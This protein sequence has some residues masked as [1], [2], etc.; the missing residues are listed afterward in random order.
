MKVWFEGEVIDRAYPNDRYLRIVEREYSLHWVDEYSQEHSVVV[1]VNFITD[2]ASVPRPL[3]NIIPPWDNYIKDAAVCHDRMY[4]TNEVD[5]ATADSL[6]YY[7]M[8]VRGAS[9]VGA[10]AVWT[11]VRLFGQSSYE[12]GEKRQQERI[13]KLQRL[14]GK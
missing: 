8:L 1:P 3:W 2:L 10:Y 4:E 5:R 9:H 11:G 13:K 12:T 14:G 6:L 7:G